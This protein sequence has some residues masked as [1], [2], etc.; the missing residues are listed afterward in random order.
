M[1]KKNGNKQ[2]VRIG[3]VEVKL[4]YPFDLHQVIDGVYIFVLEC[5]ANDIFMYRRNILAFDSTGQRLWQVSPSPYLIAGY[6]TF[7]CQ[8]TSLYQKNGQ[9][10]TQSSGTP[11]AEFI[12]DIKSGKVFFDDGSEI[13][14]Q[15]D[16]VWEDD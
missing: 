2:T 16:R 1:T 6:K 14:I 13:P 12:V 7:P 4:P 3:E 9:L 10:M 15:P 11:H 5:D 8:W